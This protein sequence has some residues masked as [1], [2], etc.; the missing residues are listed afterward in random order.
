MLCNECSNRG[1]CVKL[2]KE[3]EYFVNQDY[4]KRSSYE[5]L[6]CELK[7]NIEEIIEN[8]YPEVETDLSL[9][10]WKYFVKHYKMTRKQ[11]RY[12]FLKYWKYLSYKNI[13]KKCSVDPSSVIRTIKRF[14]EKSQ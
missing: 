12:I 3:A 11:K 6:E 14:L 2:C 13:G 9:N 8:D 1:I 5:R 4:I 7:H 10:D